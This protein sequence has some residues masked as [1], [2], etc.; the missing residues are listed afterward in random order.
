MLFREE[1]LEDDLITEIEE[2]FPDQQAEVETNGYDYDLNWDQYKNISKVLRVY[3]VRENKRLVGYASYILNNSIH[4]KTKL[5]AANDSIYILPDYRKSGTGRDFLAF[6]EGRL[7]EEGV[8]SASMT[9]KNK[10]NF[11]KMLIETGYELEET[12]YLKRL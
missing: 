10:V 5:F 2:L 1:I 4:Y 3:T 6:C 9:V 7:A 12:N 11:S 8:K